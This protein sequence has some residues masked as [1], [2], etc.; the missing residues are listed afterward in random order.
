M[1]KR[2]TYELVNGKTNI[3]TYE[4]DKQNFKVILQPIHLSKPY[5]QNKYGIG[6]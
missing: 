3:P 4:L 2:A 1:L 5:T 6:G